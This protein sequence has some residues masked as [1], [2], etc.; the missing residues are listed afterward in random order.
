MKQQFTPNFDGPSFKEIIKFEFISWFGRKFRKNRSKIILKQKPL[1]L[2]LG[3]G[4]NFTEGWVHVDFF[5]SP[6]IKFRK[7]KI[8]SRYSLI[9]A[10]FRYPI[11]C[12]E[13]SVDGIYSGH[14]IEHLYPGEAYQFLCEIFRILRPGCWLRINFPDLEKYINY[15]N[16]K[17]SAS[18]FL[19]FNTGC[20]AISNITQNYGHHSVWDEKLITDALNNIGFINIKRVKFGKE[21][22]D[23]RLIKE[24]EIRKWETLVVEAQ[25]PL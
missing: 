2:D 25:K 8:L 15:Y 5:K 12:D 23:K 21:G 3:C 17:E 24:E 9:E 19:V 16:G 4:S 18:E 22:T 14:T 10:D 11:R 7:N 1:L 20:E 13:N 6:Q